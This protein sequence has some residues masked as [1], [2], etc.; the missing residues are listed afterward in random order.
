MKLR[1]YGSILKSPNLKF[2]NISVIDSIGLRSHC[3]L[4][5]PSGIHDTYITVKLT[6]FRIECHLLGEKW[7]L[8]DLTVCS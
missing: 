8:N 5:P 7:M 1:P 6:I 2:A 3:N 4:G